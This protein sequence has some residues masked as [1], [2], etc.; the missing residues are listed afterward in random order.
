[1]ASMCFYLRLV[2]KEAVNDSFE[3]ILQ[4]SIFLSI[5]IKSASKQK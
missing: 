4:R 5:D 2:I 3:N 1:M